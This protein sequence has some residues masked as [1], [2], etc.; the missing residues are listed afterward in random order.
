MAFNACYVIK[1]TIFLNFI[2]FALYTSA[3][4]PTEKD[5]VCPCNKDEDCQIFTGIN[6][7]FKMTYKPECGEN[8]K[9]INTFSKYGCLSGYSFEKAMIEYMKDLEFKSR[10]E[11]AKEGLPLKLEDLEN[12]NCN[13]KE[14]NRKCRVC[15]PGD[16]DTQHCTNYTSVSIYKNYT[17][18]ILSQ[19]WLST[20]LIGQLAQIFAVEILKLPTIFV[21]DNKNYK[22]KSDA[23]SN[24][25]GDEPNA[26]NP[27]IIHSKGFYED[28]LDKP[29]YG[30]DNNQ[31]YN[32]G[33]IAMCNDA[34]NSRNNNCGDAMMEVWR[35]LDQQ[36]TAD[37]TNLRPMPLGITGQIG[38]YIPRY[39]V[40][41]YPDLASYRGFTEKY[42]KRNAKIFKYPITWNDYCVNYYNSSSNSSSVDNVERICPIPAKY[43][44]D[45]KDDY[46]KRNDK[47]EIVYGGYFVADDD[48]GYLTT[49]DL[50]GW[51]EYSKIMFHGNNISI[52]YKGR[53][54]STRGG[55]T[56]K[57]IDQILSASAEN[58]EAFFM[59]WWKP[60][61]LPFEVKLNKESHEMIRV[62]FPP[63]TS[64]CREQQGKISAHKVN[65]E[66]KGVCYVEKNKT[67]IDTKY[68][69]SSCDYNADPLDK[70]ISNLLIREGKNLAGALYYDDNVSKPSY[71]FLKHFMINDELLE[72][73]IVKFLKMKKEVLDSGKPIKS[74]EQYLINQAVCEFARIKMDTYLE[75]GKEKKESA[76]NVLS[77][78]QGWIK[79]VN[80]KY[81][82]PNVEA[83]YDR[84]DFIRY[85]FLIFQILAI[86]G[87]VFCIA[88][89]TLVWK[90]RKTNKE[91]KRNQPLY[92]M[93]ILSGCILIYIHV[94]LLMTEP[95]HDSKSKTP[96]TIHCIAS[97]FCLHL[98]IVVALVPLFV[99]LGTI[100]KLLIAS[101]RRM[102]KHRGSREARYMV[103]KTVIGLSFTMIYCIVWT[104]V[105]WDNS[106]E[107]QLKFS[108]LDVDGKKIFIYRAHCE[109]YT[110]PNE[111][112]RFKTIIT[113]LEAFLLLY[114]VKLAMANRNVHIKE[115]NSSKPVAFSLYNIMFSQ[116]IP[117]LLSLQFIRFEGDG[118]SIDLFFGMALWWSTTVLVIFYYFPKVAKVVNSSCKKINRSIPSTNAMIRSLRTANSSRASSIN[119]E[120]EDTT[121]NSQ[122]TNISHI[123]VSNPAFNL[124]LTKKNPSKKDSIKNK[125]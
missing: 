120:S 97:R 45:Y 3:C 37:I 107:P 62:A 76:R 104:I 38:L 121:N 23:K 125:V 95:S 79:G 25:Y 91:I 41:M 5:N 24:Y 30:R 49:I 114:G 68:K 80:E 106:S 94:L 18:K 17:L 10:L 113:C 4:L 71:D 51:S 110:G 70:V 27:N 89:A 56:L 118:S 61:V 105:E 78:M 7:K 26:K 98:G 53:N 111:T 101:S 112:D 19:N 108:T 84:T 11:K 14:H 43:M 74:V 92:T 39:L 58:D 77:M 86:L 44:K 29:M 99:I 59:W 9:C 83:F 60:D 63:S 67:I 22:K 100:T 42:R 52:G 13:D 34:K 81:L 2:Y 75:D 96:G 124:E 66:I 117:L 55:Y 85:L 20:Q 122:E 87:I 88:L 47:N 116:A 73:I 90:N 21:F 33:S 15:L 8:R 40:D 12:R 50:C 123:E 69:D 119:S 57:H 35:T 6:T 103:Y 65:G 102:S 48:I 31:A 1:Y 28:Y 16:F 36:I 115:F 93:V 82:A 32:L 109:V 46:Y 64:N 72:E 54:N